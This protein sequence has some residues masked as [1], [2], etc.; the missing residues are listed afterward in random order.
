M[1]RH[2]C[3]VCRKGVKPTHGDTIARHVDKAHID[4]CPASGE[5]FRIAVEMNITRDIRAVQ[6][7]LSFP[8]R[9][10]ELRYDMELPIWQVAKQM[11]LSLASLYRMLLRNNMTVPH[12]LSELVQDTKPRKKVPA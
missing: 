8:E 11:K 3:P 10:A 2:E 7:T 12:E 9:Y 4:T 5:P 6:T 1:I